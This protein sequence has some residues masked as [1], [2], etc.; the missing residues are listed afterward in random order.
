[1]IDFQILAKTFEKKLA[2]IKVAAFDVDGCLTDGRVWWDGE[3]LG[4]NRSTNTLD[5]YGLKLLMKMGIKTGVI[6]GGDSVSVRER[7]KKNLNLDFIFLGSEDKREAYKRILAMGFGDEEILFMGDEFFD[8]PLLLQAGFS[9]TTSYA[10]PELQGIADYV[11]QRPPGEGCVR[12]V[13]DLLRIQRAYT[14]EILDF[15][16]RAIRF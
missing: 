3:A 15:H 7:F 6:S 4:F 11:C 14:P 5:G 13:I 10:S 12:E 1:M 2:P 9:A 16:D 8:A